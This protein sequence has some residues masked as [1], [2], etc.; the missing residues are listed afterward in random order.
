MAFP[1]LLAVIG[2]T[3]LALAG[4]TF[5][6]FSTGVMPGLRRVDDATFVASMR[7]INRAVLNPLFLVP[8][9]VAPLLLAW[10]ALLELDSRGGGLLLAAALVYFVG[11]VVVTAAG[12]V[13]LN[14]ALD[15][16]T[17]PPSQTRAAFERRWNGLNTVRSIASVVAIALAALG[18]V[19][20]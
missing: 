15:G 20:A 9:F 16:S 2:I 4:G 5:W 3:L 1:D 14:T 17:A 10:A 7:A 19:V 6:S 13:P 8:I 11:G 18:L 12:N